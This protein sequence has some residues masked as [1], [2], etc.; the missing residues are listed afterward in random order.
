MKIIRLPIDCSRGAETAHIFGQDRDDALEM[1][2]LTVDFEQ[3]LMG[4]S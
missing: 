1:L 2:E 3:W 4:D